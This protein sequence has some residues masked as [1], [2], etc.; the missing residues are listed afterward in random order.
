MKSTQCERVKFY[1]Q[2]ALIRIM[3]WKY[4]TY[5]AALAAISFFIPPYCM[6]R[7]FVGKEEEFLRPMQ[8]L[9]DRIAA[10]CLLDSY[11]ENKDRLESEINKKRKDL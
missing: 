8:D 7:V 9:F 10:S 5:L 3:Y 2:V 4:G 6:Y 11:L 1:T